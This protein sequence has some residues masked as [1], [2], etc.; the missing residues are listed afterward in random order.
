MLFDECKQQILAIAFVHDMLYAS[1][2]LKTIKV[3]TFIKA[4]IKNQVNSKNY[5]IDFKIEDT[6]M[7]MDN[8]IP[9]GLILIECYINTLKHAFINGEEKNIFIGLTRRNDEV[10]F[11]FKDN[12]K[13]FPIHEI[14][15][16]NPYLIKVL[17]RQIDGHLSTYNN[18]GAVIE[19]KFKDLQATTSE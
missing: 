16:T 2:D 8:L 3:N 19:I 12:G 14:K 7:N 5:D 11:I 13:G 10:D 9:L 18:N 15:Q 17:T 1:N 4:L 6:N